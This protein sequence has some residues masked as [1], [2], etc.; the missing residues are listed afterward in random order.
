[1]TVSMKSYLINGVLALTIYLTVIGCE[2]DSQ[3]K[4]KP[5]VGSADKIIYG[6]SD[7]D[8]NYLGN[9]LGFQVEALG[10]SGYI[11]SGDSFDFGVVAHNDI[12][13]ESRV[14][15]DEPVI[16]RYKSSDG[17]RSEESWLSVSQGVKLGVVEEHFREFVRRLAK[18]KN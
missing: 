17:K 4:S 9:R 8:L 7:E 16:L 13:V 3:S 11:F 15:A 2:S 12:S 6:L 10:M 14:Q 5:A 18:E 1:M